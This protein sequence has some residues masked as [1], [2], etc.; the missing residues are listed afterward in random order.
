M[1]FTQVYRTTEP[2]TNHNTKR[3]LI[4]TASNLKVHKYNYNIASKFM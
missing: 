2:L 4:I 3:N 1:I